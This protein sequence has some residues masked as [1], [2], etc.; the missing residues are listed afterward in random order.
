MQALS[1][2][3]LTLFGGEWC[4]LVLRFQC[5]CCKSVYKAKSPAKYVPAGCVRYKLLGVAVVHA[6]AV[7][8]WMQTFQSRVSSLSYM[9][10]RCPT[11]CRL[12]RPTGTPASDHQMSLTE[13]AG[14]RAVCFSSTI[15]EVR[16]DVHSEQTHFRYLL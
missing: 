7:P 12:S 11:G 13:L 10:E 16:I 9:R 15:V 14:W 3:H 8:Y 5:D 4:K 1:Y 2:A 6:S